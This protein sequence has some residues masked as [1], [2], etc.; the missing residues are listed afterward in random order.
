VL[1]KLGQAL[2]D[3]FGI[4]RHLRQR[5]R[6]LLGPHGGGNQHKS[7]YGHQKGRFFNYDSPSGLGFRDKNIIFLNL[8]S[9]G[10]VIFSTF[11]REGFSRWVNR[12]LEER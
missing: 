1:G 9:Q 12:R 8:G 10:F 7:H 3:A 2:N 4:L 6:Y 5:I 11:V